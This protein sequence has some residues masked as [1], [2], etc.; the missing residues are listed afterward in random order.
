MRD[1]LKL[2]AHWHNLGALVQGWAQ[3]RWQSRVLFFLTHVLC[4]CLRAGLF[5][6]WTP[7]EKEKTTKRL[8]ISSWGKKKRKRQTKCTGVSKG[9]QWGKPHGEK[10]KKKKKCKRRVFY[11]W[12]G[13]LFCFAVCQISWA[14]R[15]QERERERKPSRNN[16][17]A[18]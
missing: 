17:S 11:I 16:V 14:A 18:G 6:L 7:L 3:S 1:T 12:P 5:Y 4:F 2:R 15:K 9:K 10:E 8:D 13:H